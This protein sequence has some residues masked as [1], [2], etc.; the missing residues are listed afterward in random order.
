M[1]GAVEQAER[2]KAFV[3]YSRDDVAF[4]DQLVIGLEHLGFKAILDR[5]DIDAAENWKQRLSG[6]I[7]SCDTV[8][9]VL[10]ERS[11]TSP[12]CGWEVDEALRHGKRIVPVVPR[13]VKAAPPPA[14]SDLNWIHFYPTQTI[15]GSGMLDGMAKLDRALRVDLN[16]L[17]QQT[18]LSE[19]AALW[20]VRMDRRADPSEPSSM[21]LRGN[22][23]QEAYAWV[24]SAPKGAS[25]PQLLTDYL[26]ASTQAETQSKAEAE[27]QIAER[28]AAL[29]QAEDAVAAAS[30]ANEKAAG[31]QKKRARS[32]RT[33]RIL[34]ASSLVIGLVLSAA[35]L[36]GGWQAIVARVDAV[37]SSSTAFAR[38]S[39]A[40]NQQGRHAEA[41]LMTLQGDPAGEGRW[42]TRLPGFASRFAAAQTALQRSYGDQRLVEKF[43]SQLDTKDDDRGAEPSQSAIV[44]LPPIEGEKGRRFLS[45]SGIEQG[46]G[47]SERGGGR[48]WLW[49]EGQAEPL[50]EFKT[51]D[52]DW[53][54]AGVDSKGRGTGG[55]LAIAITSG[56]TP[57]KEKFIALYSRGTIVSWQ[58]GAIRP[59]QIL[60]IYGP[61][62]DYEAWSLAL[63]PGIKDGPPRVLVGLG[64]GDVQLWTLGS[65][66]PD[67]TYVSPNG[68]KD[69]NWG[70]YSIAVLPGDDPG[71]EKFAVGYPGGLVHLWRAVDGN[72]SFECKTEPDKDAPTFSDGHP[73]RLAVMPHYGK[74]ENWFASTRGGGDILFW[75][76]IIPDKDTEPLSCRAQLLRPAGARSENS[77]TALAALPTGVEFVNRLV[78]AHQ[79]GTVRTWEYRQYYGAQVTEINTG[80][81]T[82]LT[83]IAAP[84]DANDGTVLV[85]RSNGAIERW[86]QK[87]TRPSGSAGPPM[88][89]A[90][91]KTVFANQHPK[92]LLV[93]P[94]AGDG[95]PVIVAAHMDS[96]SWRDAMTTDD[97]LDDHHLKGWRAGAENP[98]WDIRF[99]NLDRSFDAELQVFP[100]GDPAHPLLLAFNGDNLR[101]DNPFSKGSMSAA[102]WQYGKPEPVANLTEQF[103]PPRFDDVSGALPVLALRADDKGRQRLL[104][105]A[106]QRGQR[107]TDLLLW[108]VGDKGKPLLI[109]APE[110]DKSTG[111][112]TALV[113]VPPRNDKDPDEFLVAY[114][115]GAVVHWRVGDTKPLGRLDLP[116]GAANSLILLGHA[117]SGAPRF[118]ASRGARP[119]QLWSLDGH[120]PEAS[121]VTGADAYSVAVL[122]RPPGAEGGINFFLTADHNF[123]TRQAEVKLWRTDSPNPIAAYRPDAYGRSA[124]GANFMALP[125]AALPD[126]TSFAL[127]GYDHPIE[128]WRIDPI[129]FAAPK[130]QVRMTCEALLDMG[131]TQFSEQDIQDFPILE[132]PL[133]KDPCADVW[134]ETQQPVV[135]GSAKVPAKL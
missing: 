89:P 108:T 75:E 7:L 16:W 48:I 43:T 58:V 119:L 15:P 36:W 49:R 19:Q 65:K 66:T 60:R 62:E 104:T 99:S 27:A 87:T 92:E 95:Q 55:V 130:E 112:P 127:P 4:A 96:T 51:S 56:G 34:A 18:R 121:F 98:D 5:H 113:R 128:I 64:N 63:L 80:A 134:P 124:N 59:E 70:A 79:D 14:L 102:I 20:R 77:I 35:A 12:I 39:L 40:L 47:F 116:H 78:A 126:G 32:E 118:L 90:N 2:M 45:A 30:A 8:I 76:A 109:P 93:L 114:S 9:F 101:G 105:A 83:A 17:R 115:G 122:P 31:E 22:V 131:V 132:A 120:E 81:G 135:P 110:G 129:H 85:G 57:G 82:R 3:S 46:D 38:E 69:D 44:F 107:V 50:G 33:T 61:S 84:L 23:L 68:G 97:A 10:T 103:K 25:I 74:N 53:A 6:L 26:N 11:A 41:L 67:R 94:Q 117:K 72:T 54:K 106:I 100:G 123:V 42:E 52:E 29:K 28:A 125:I 91:Y 71:D 21:L 86:R 24:Q 37:A 133:V 13:E 111:A 73:T 88:L 1:N